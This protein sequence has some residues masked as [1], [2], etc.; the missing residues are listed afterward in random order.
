MEI[1]KPGYLFNSDG[2][3]ATRPSI[4]GAPGAVGYGDTFTVTTPDAANISSVILVRDG[5]VTHAFGMDQ[6]EV[7][8]SFTAGAEH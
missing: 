8:L 2:T 4:T 3:S 7:A 6:R 5:S 1:Y